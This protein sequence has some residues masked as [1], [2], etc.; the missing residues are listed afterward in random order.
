MTALHSG[1]AKSAELIAHTEM[2]IAYSPKCQ[3]ESAATGKTEWWKVL[4]QPSLRF[5]RTDPTAEPQG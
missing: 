3:F 1:K 2:V 4:E 5:G